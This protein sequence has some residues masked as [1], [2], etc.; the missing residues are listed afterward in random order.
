MKLMSILNELFD[1]PWS[2]VKNEEVTKK[3]RDFYYSLGYSM[4]NAFTLEN[5]NGY[6]MSCVK[7]DAWEVHHIVG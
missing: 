4:I 3:L 2:Y 7:D 5:D 6:V 1:S